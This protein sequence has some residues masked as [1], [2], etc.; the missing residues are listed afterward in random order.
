MFRVRHPEGIN[1]QTWLPRLRFADKN[2]LTPCP[3]V[4]PGFKEI[5]AVARKL[6]DLGLLDGGS[7]RG[8]LRVQH[9]RDGVLTD[10]GRGLRPF[11]V[12]K[13]SLCAVPC[14][15]VYSRRSGSRTRVESD[16]VECCGGWRQPG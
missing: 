4:L 6:T 11:S 9:G 10:M 16:R 12:R 14:D 15:V 8:G 3:R 5:A 13:L 1:R 7:Y 2:E